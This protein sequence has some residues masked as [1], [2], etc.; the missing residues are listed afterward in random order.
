MKKTFWPALIVAVLLVACWCH[1][2]AAYALK[3]KVW[4]EGQSQLIIQGNTA[5]WHNLS[6]VAPGYEAPYGDPPAPTYL[7][8]KNMKTMAWTPGAW[9]NG[10]SGDTTSDK[11]TGL[12]APLAA[13]EQTVTLTANHVRDM[14]A[15]IQQPA[16]ANGYTLIV[17][18]DDTSSGG[19]YWYEVSLEYTSGVPFQY[20][21]F[22][23]GM[24][25]SQATALNARGQATGE[26]WN[27]NGSTRT[28]RAYFWDPKAK[29]MLDLGTPAEWTESAGWAINKKGQVAG[30][31]KQGDLNHIFFWDRANGMQDL[32]TLGGNM[33]FVASHSSINDKGYLCGA[34]EISPGGP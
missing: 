14:A 30:R 26:S 25:D 15:I 28:S 16:A 7:T 1:P 5:Q 29:T 34:S 8:T 13:V 31:L 4:I 18:F 10:T 9:S 23:E 6:Y 2:A 3:V 24:T 12:S 17:D 32:G 20:L 27:N 11:F 33:G 22:L 21:G 19:A